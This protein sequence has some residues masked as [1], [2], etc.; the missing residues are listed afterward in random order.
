VDPPEIS[1]EDPS[2]QYSKC[3]QYYK[4]YDLEVH[5]KK[6]GVARCKKC[7]G[8][9]NYNQEVYKLYRHL[10]NRH[11]SVYK[12]LYNGEDTTTATMLKA[13]KSKQHKRKKA[14]ND[15]EDNDYIPLKKIANHPYEGDDNEMTQE[16]KRAEEKH[17]LEMWEDARCKMK[18]IREDIKVESDDEMI[19]DLKTDMKGLR[20]RKAHFAQLLGM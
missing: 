15:T 3:W 2:N 1:L 20:K 17:W 6:Q 9:I 7:D 8:D 14:T 18:Q 16:E 10:A 4:L 11:P 5:P 12:E 19:E 13:P